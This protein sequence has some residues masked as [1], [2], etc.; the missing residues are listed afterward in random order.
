MTEAFA[1]LITPGVATAIA[2]MALVT[3]LC[4]I[5]GYYMMHVIP[6][7]GRLKRA[8]A[9][10]PG[11]IIA[12]AVLPSLERL[13]PAAMLAIGAAVLTMLI[14]RNEIL[15]LLVGLGIAAAARAWGM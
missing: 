3:Y 9:A 13:G 15:A 14:R 4:R 6:I 1:A 5:A 10:L 12:A 11:S 8:F 2:A 7:T